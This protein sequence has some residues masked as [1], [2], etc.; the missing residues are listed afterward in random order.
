MKTLSEQIQELQ[1]KLNARRDLLLAATKA[2]EEDASEENEGAIVE[3]TAELEKMTA[4]M[5]TLKAAEKALGVKADPVIKQAPAVIKGRDKSTDTD[6]LLGKMALCVYE[7]RVKSLPLDVVR[8]NRFGE[9]EALDTFIKAAQNPAM[10]NVPGYAQELTQI[11]YGQFMD[12]LREEALLPKATPIMQQHQFNGATSI[13]V[14]MR[15]GGTT[16]AAAVFR[17]E[18]SPIPVKA[19]QFTSQ[20]M[21]P[22]NMGVILT[23]T[24]EMLSRSSIDLAGYFQSA[25]V[26]DTAE[27]LDLIFISNTAGTAIQP[28]G[29]RNALP[30]G[31]T[32]P[33]SGTG[34]IT[35]I[36]ADVKAMI[37]T[38]VNAKMGKAGTTRWIMSPANWLTVGMALTVTGA[39]QFPE[40]TQGKL[41]FYDV[42]TTTQIPDNVI[43][44]VDFG[45]ISAGFGSP[46]FLA[47]NVA[48]L[49]EENTNPLPI[50]APGAPNVVAAPVR[51]LYQT[52]SWAL[53]MMLDA[54][55]K[56][57][58]A[59]GLVQELTAVAWVG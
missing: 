29:I 51:S 4:R 52:N 13:Y 18:G 3:H 39:K 22:K 54:D 53:R 8:V 32:R 19:L 47:S 41:S 58:R 27:G 28:A 23:A 5:E 20:S 12:L 10:S 1:E 44:L 45:H 42:L 2:F 35:D 43:L 37:T 16:D 31:D 26:T 9:S 57:L 33:A 25:M 38:M 55:W 59:A 56:K 34:T 21:T 46:N 49:H 48:T 50:S 11:A 7:S 36:V 24:E 40:T 17:A 6:F 30:P 15:T 14:P